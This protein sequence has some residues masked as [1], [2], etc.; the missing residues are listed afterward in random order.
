MSKGTGGRALKDSNQP[1]YIARDR[2]FPHNPLFKSH[3]VLDENAR[4]QVW[5]RV[6]RQGETIKAVSAELG[7]D[8]TRVAAIVRLKEVEKDWLAKVSRFLEVLVLCF[9]SCP[10][11]YD[12]I[13]QK[14]SISLE[15]I[16]MVTNT[17]CEPL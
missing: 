10:F 14:F 2:P 9:Q 4:E 11:P 1:R 5:N 6:I 7:V 12:D 17:C 16:Y 13:Q 8:I 15:D 3:P